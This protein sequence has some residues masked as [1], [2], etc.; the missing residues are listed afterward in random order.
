LRIT[1]SDPASEGTRLLSPEASFMVL[2]MLRQHVRP[3]ETSGAQPYAAPVYWKTGTSWAF[4]D[5]WTAG[6]F[7]PYVLVIWVGNFDGSANPAFVGVDAAAP[8]FFQI[9]DAVRAEQP[10]AAGHLITPPPGVKRVAICLASGALPNRWCPERGSTWFIP[11]KSP[12]AVS[13]VHRPVMIDDA[14]GMPACPPYD[15]KKVHQEIYEFWPSDLAQVF[16]AA[17]IP[18]RKPPANSAC[19]NAGAVEG[20]GPSITSPMRGSAYTLRLTQ[21]ERENIPLDATTDAD[22]HALYWFVDDALIGKTNPGTPL[23]WR[24]PFAGTFRIRAVDDH[25]RSDS[26]TL[27]VVQER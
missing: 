25:A 7:G 12:I 11:G 8:L 1:A 16:I 3:D 4:R 15:G 21:P 22:T 2:D 14:T 10:D 5:A 6:A 17:G 24:P 23:Y 20:E 19:V 26:R 13:D 9:V 27:S 18:R